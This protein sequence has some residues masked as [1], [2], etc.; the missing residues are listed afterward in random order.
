MEKAAHSAAFD[1]ILHD[2][3]GIFFKVAK[4]YCPN[5]DDRPD[6]VQDMLLQVWQALPSYKA[7]FKLSTWLYRIALNVAISYYR[8][9]AAQLASRAPVGLEVIDVADEPISEPNPQ[10]LRL[11]GFIQELNDLDKAL[12]LLYLEE[13]PQS[14]IAEI[15][16]ISQ[17]NVST[18][19]MRIKEKLKH[20]LQTPVR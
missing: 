5:P 12:M 15:L 10:L 14:E 16:G 17:S 8:K 13:K 11:E 9:N 4:T 2:H 18:K 1:R 20:R 3:K 19:V 6:L 7:D